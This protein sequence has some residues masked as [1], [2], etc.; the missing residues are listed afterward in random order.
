MDKFCSDEL[1]NSCCSLFPIIVTTC[2]GLY[3]IKLFLLKSTFLG[4]LINIATDIKQKLLG[5]IVS[6]TAT[7]NC[8]KSFKLI[9]DDITNS[10]EL[11]YIM[12][13]V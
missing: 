6:H 13:T 8:F 7:I 1:M 5:I 12:L 2:N 10:L 3:S 11:H 4:K 9:V